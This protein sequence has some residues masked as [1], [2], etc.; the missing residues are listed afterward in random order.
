VKMVDFSLCWRLKE[1]PIQVNP[2]GFLSIKIAVFSVDGSS[3][4]FLFPFDVKVLV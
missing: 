1:F 3:F 4:S 2:H